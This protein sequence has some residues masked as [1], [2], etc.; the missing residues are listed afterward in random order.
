MTSSELLAG[1][2]LEGSSS[3]DIRSEATGAEYQVRVATPPGYE[4]LGKHYPLLIVLDGCMLFGT[5]A[6]TVASQVL[7]Q[8][9]RPIIVAAVSTRGSMREHNLR[10]LRDYTPAGMGTPPD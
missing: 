3:F 8:E 6:E 2:Y 9:I 5:A 1:S 4:D 7:T 10:R